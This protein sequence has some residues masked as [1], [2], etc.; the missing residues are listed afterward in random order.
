MV[1]ALASNSLMGCSALGDTEGEIPYPEGIPSGVL[2]GHAYAIID[3]FEIEVQLLKQDDDGNEKYQ[4]EMVKLVRLRNPW[5][6]KEWN[7]AWSDASEE[8][9]DNMKA[10]NDYIRQCNREQEEKFK[11]YPELI[12]PKDLFDADAND[13]TFLMNFEAWR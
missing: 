8:L 6:K 4:A 3:A 11:D 13:G 5:G 2:S 9:D 7:G 12:D 1:R 10:L